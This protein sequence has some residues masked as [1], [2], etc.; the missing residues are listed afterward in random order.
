MENASKAL[1]IIGAVLL[2]IMLIG[3]VMY[4]L[5]RAGLF[6]RSQATEETAHTLNEYNAQYE[7]FNRSNLTGGDIISICN[8]AYN[9]NRDDA[10]VEIEIEVRNAFDVGY[11][12]IVEKYNIPDTGTATEEEISRVTTYLEDINV[13]KIGSTPANEKEYMAKELQS[14][15]KSDFSCISRETEYDDLTGEISRMVFER[16]PE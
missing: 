10:E 12:R 11:E 3:T 6:F 4:I 16:V 1:V 15:R 13:S 14:F 7:A 9:H 2:G 5:N 8:K